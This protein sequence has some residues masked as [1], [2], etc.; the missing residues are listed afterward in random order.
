MWG[1]E[2]RTDCRH[3][4][5]QQRQSVVG[6]FEKLPAGVDEASDGEDFSHLID[7]PL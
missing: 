6:Q 7:R 5:V 1:R 2:S 4:W 3:C